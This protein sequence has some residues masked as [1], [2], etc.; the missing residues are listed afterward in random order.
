MKKKTPQ[1]QAPSPVQTDSFKIA[2]GERAPAAA[3]FSN[4]LPGSPGMSEFR[5][6]L[7]GSLAH[8]TA[9]T[10]E[11]AIARSRERAAASGFG[12]SD[13]ITTSAETGLANEQAGRIAQIPAQVEQM[14]APLELQ[15]SGALLNDARGYYGAGVG[16]EDQ[17]MADFYKQQEEARRKKAGIWGSL[18]KIGLNVGGSFLGV[19]GLGSGV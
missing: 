9:K 3:G 8:S 12:F 14:A 17:R 16:L 6:A 1:P 19:P 13:P 11:N 4:Y 10:G 2:E 5:R 15:A 18:A 7:T